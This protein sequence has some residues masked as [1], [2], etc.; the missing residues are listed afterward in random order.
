MSVIANEQPSNAVDLDTLQVQ[1]A[2]MSN[3]ELLMFGKQTHS[4][5]RP[6]TY[7]GSGKPQVSAF[8]IR[9]DEVRDGWR[10]RRRNHS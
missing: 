7:G 8:S 3:A 1:L 5:Y 10:K 6:L 4:L 2:Q 9:S